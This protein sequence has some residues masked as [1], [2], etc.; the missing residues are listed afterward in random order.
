MNKIIYITSEN[1]CHMSGQII[2]TSA[3]S[4]WNIWFSTG[5]PPQCPNTSGLGIMEV[6][7]SSVIHEI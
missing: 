3:E 6:C 4:F 1:M 5:I 2:A 7:P